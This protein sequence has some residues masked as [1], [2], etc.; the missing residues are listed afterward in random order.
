MNSRYALGKWSR[1]MGRNRSKKVYKTS[2]CKAVRIHPQRRHQEYFTQAETS[3][4][5][6]CQF[7]H[8]GRC[9]RCSVRRMTSIKRQTGALALLSA[10]DCEHGGAADRALTLHRRFPVLHGHL[11]SVF[12]LAFVF[13]FHTVVKLLCHSRLVSLHPF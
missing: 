1:E 10:D 12:H 3:N 11:L 9:P 6:I 4:E 5:G 13:A 8:T 2:V 7:T